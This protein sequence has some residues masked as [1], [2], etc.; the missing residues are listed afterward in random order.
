MAQHRRTPSRGPGALSAEWRIGV[1]YATLR[2]RTCRWRGQNTNS[3]S[4]GVSTQHARREVAREKTFEV[5]GDHGR[6]IASVDRA[7][8]SGEACAFAPGCRT[9]RSRCQETKKT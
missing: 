3:G 9:T 5:L 8:A 2:L 6:R 4:F 1:G 7:A